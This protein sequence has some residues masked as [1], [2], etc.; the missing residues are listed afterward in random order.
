MQILIVTDS[1]G[2]VFPH[3]IERV[4]ARLAAELSR[5]RDVVA[6]AT[7]RSGS[8]VVRAQS[9]TAG[10]FPDAVVFRLDPGPIDALG[11]PLDAAQAMSAMDEVLDRW[12]PDVVHFTVVRGLGPGVVRQVRNRGI[13]V[14]LDLH[15]FEPGCP[16]FTLLNSTGHTCPGPDGGRMCAATCFRTV[17]GSGARAAERLRG[18]SEAIREADAVTACSDFLAGWVSE[19]CEVAKPCVVAPPVLP[20]EPGIPLDLRA[21]PASRGRLNVALLGH[22]SAEKGTGLAVEAMACGQLG[23]AQLVVL[24]PVVDQRLEMELKRRAASL[25][26]F[27]LRVVGPIQPTDLSTFLFDV[28]VLVV[29]SHMPETYSLAAREAW[30]RGIPVLAVRRGALPAAVREGVNGF[31]FPPN[32]TALGALLRRIVDEPDLLPELRRGAVAT[33]FMTPSEHATVMR[34]IYARLVDGSPATAVPSEAEAEEAEQ[35]EETDGVGLAARNGDPKFVRRKRMITSPSHAEVFSDVYARDEWR[36][37]GESSSGPG[38]RREHTVRLRRELPQLL[39]RL[40]VR[41]LLDLGCGDFN[42]MRETD[43]SGVDLY[44]GIDV[45]FDVVLANRLCHGSPRRRFLRRDL[46]HDPLPRADLVLCRDVLIHFPNEELVTAINAIIASRSRYLLAGTYVG[47]QENR[48]TTLPIWRP[49]NLQLPP[50][51]LPPPQE[52]LIETPWETGHEDKRLGLW[53]LRALR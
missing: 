6:V 4:V 12:R 37:G 46:T 30:S 38:S 45:V 47:R 9:H 16:R 40:G 21:I 32:P 26:D 43:L 1:L 52:C 27:D 53:D 41:R 51:S 15:C 13:P 29:A 44:I 3:G 48:Q 14:V 35:T 2:E 33:P 28:D 17:P 31:T 49:I 10:C 25:P 19:T 7:T 8:L 23:P 24:G 18:F 20:P 36:L 39:S 22:V 34:E 11:V 42:W 50:V 5:R